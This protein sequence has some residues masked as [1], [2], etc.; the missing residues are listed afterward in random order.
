MFNNQF[1]D[2]RT[3]IKWANM[4][5][6]SHGNL[7]VPSWVHALQQTSLLPTA[8]YS[9]WVTCEMH[10]SFEVTLPVSSRCKIAYESRIP[11]LSESDK[12]P[13]GER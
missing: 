8:N 10:L 7:P 12:R 6:Y 9:Y 1:P 5:T 2:W 3:Y 4:F 11:E 13:H